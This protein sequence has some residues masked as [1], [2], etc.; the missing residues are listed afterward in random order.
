MQLI[1]ESKEHLISDGNSSTSLD[2]LESVAG[3]RFVLLYVSE[4]L[5]ASKYIQQEDEHSDFEELLILVKALC[6]N[7]A[8]NSI[9]H[10]P[11]TFLLKNIFRRCGEMSFHRIIGEHGLNWILPVGMAR[12]TEV[13]LLAL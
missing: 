8:V 2:C 7:K 1:T 5:V 6:S 9:S 10:G 13:R 11:Q 3:I 4:Q 12:D